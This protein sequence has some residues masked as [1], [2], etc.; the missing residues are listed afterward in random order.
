MKATVS[1]RRI[2]TSLVD[3]LFPL[4]CLGCDREGSL[5]CPSCADSLPR[6]KQPI[7]RCCGTRIRDGELCASC[8]SHSMSIDGIRSVLLFGGTARQAVHGLKYKHLKAMASPLGGLLSDFLR[9]YPLPGDVLVPVPLHPRRLRE[10][11]YNQAALL[12]K[13]TGKR[14]G[15]PVEEGWLLRQRDTMTQANA[16]NAAQRHGNVR[17][18]FAC[19]R[20]LGGERGLLIDDVCSTGAT[21]DACA[22]ALKEA[23]AGSVW[24]LTVAREL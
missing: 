13:E 5:L 19:T 14:T 3:V 10:R 20:E 12:A 7:C 24:G 17:D 9:A 1:L 6:I 11:G 2:G 16:A 15:L 22:S 8:L 23:G 21:L 4:Q 18:A